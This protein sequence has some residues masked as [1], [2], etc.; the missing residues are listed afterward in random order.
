[1]RVIF[2]PKF[3]EDIRQHG[4]QY[5]Q[6]A[7]NLGQRFRVDVDAGIEAVKVSPRS[8]GHYLDIG[9]AVVREIRRRNVRSFPFFILYGF[10]DSQLVF[11]SL[12]PSRS[13]PLTWLKRFPRSK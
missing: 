1:M 5:D 12:I 10:H 13:D 3:V 6:I 8:A 7:S 2:H 11:G 4:V 9:S